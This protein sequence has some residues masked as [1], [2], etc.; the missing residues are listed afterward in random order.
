[1]Y[2]MVSVFAIDC[3]TFESGNSSDLILNQGITFRLNSDLLRNQFVD[4]EII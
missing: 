3:V 4:G 1:M 2:V